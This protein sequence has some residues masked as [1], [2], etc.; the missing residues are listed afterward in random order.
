MDTKLRFTRKPMTTLL[1]GILA[2]AMAV[3]LCIGAALWF[4][5][6]N[7]AAVLDEHHAA[8][9]Y[10]KDRGVQQVDDPS[11]PGVEYKMENRDLAQA[12]AMAEPVQLRAGGTAVL[13]AG[14]P[15]GI[16]AGS[17]DK[18]AGGQGKFRDPLRCDKFKRQ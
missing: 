5:T 17:A 3:F 18:A 12:Q 13:S 14:I 11:S 7:L 8:V 2:A 10:R 4:S 16:P 15:V 6:A 9:A 1:W